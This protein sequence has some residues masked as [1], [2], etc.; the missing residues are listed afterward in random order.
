[1][2]DSIPS[3]DSQPLVEISTTLPD[4]VVADVIAKFLVGHR[5]VACAQVAGPM[6]STY[7]WQGELEQSTECRLVVKTLAA[8]MPRVV[9]AIRERHPYSVPEITARSVE[10]VDPAYLQWAR[11]SVDW[12]CDPTEPRSVDRI[13]HS[14]T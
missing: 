2:K 3:T 14:T 5:W 1:M 9:E 7:H 13:T 11:E 4:D 12:T 10:W 8:L 6:T